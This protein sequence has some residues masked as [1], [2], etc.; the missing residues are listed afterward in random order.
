MSQNKQVHQVFNCFA[1]INLKHA[2]AKNY[3]SG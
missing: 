2:L 1:K 3:V